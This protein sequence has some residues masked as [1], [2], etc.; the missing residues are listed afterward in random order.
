MT[1]FIN[2]QVQASNGNFGDPCYGTFKYL[3]AQ[4]ECQPGN[5]NASLLL[6]LGL[7]C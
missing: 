4:Y 7:T 6:Y 3:E 1:R 5:Q 2:L